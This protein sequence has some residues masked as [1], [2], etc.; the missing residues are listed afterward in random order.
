[1]AGLKLFFILVCVGAIMQV[2]LRNYAFGQENTPFL[3]EN[4]TTLSSNSVLAGQ[5]TK[6][7][8][9]IENPLNESTHVNITIFA[10]NIN[11][12]PTNNSLVMLTPC[13]SSGR[14][15]TRATLIIL[16]P[17]TSGV[18]PIEVQLWWN[19][20]KVASKVFVLNV[21]AAL[22]PS[23]W[24]AWIRVNI[25]A[26]GLA[27]MIVAVHFFNPLW[28]LR[29]Y[30]ERTKQAEEY[31]K[32][33]PFLGITALLLVLAYFFSTSYDYYYAFLPFLI[34]IRG[35]LEPVLAAGWILG[36]MSLGFFLFKRYQ[37]S[38]S[39]ARL[40]FIMLLLLFVLDWLEIPSPPFFGLETLGIVIFSV[41]ANVLLE[42]G[43]KGAFEEIRKRVKRTQ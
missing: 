40:L 3:S 28:K 42:I 36:V 9:T 35:E 25:L 29:M 22:D 14:T 6:L 43:I 2:S 24:G 18:I 4:F 12:F 34:G 41:I 13:L 32:P 31:S 1:M 17:E 30:N 38:T 33:L 16:T 19:N 39:L 21:F 7:N 11:C 15:S 20:T 10:S 26:W 37:W 27:I 5:V 8:V 23:T